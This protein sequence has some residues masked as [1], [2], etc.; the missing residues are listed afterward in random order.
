[1]FNHYSPRDLP[2]LFGDDDFLPVNPGKNSGSRLPTNKRFNKKSKL[3]APSLFDQDSES[4]N[5]TEILQEF[6]KEDRE[7]FIRMSS[8]ARQ[9]NLRLKIAQDEN[10]DEDKVYIE[11]QLLASNKLEAREYSLAIANSLQQD[12]G[13]VIIPTGL[14]KTYIAITMML[15]QLKKNSAQKILFLAPTKPL[16]N[17]HVSTLQTL[18]PGLEINKITG[19]TPKKKRGLLWRASR[20][21]VATPQ[22]ITAE[23]KSFKVKSLVGQSED[24]MML[25]IDELHHQTGH[26]D[27]V[28]LVEFYQK[29]NSDIQFVGFTASPD[30]SL[31]TI[32]GWIKQLRVKNG[33][34]EARSFDSSDIAPYSYCRQVTPHYLDRKL[35]PLQREFKTILAEEL[36]KVIKEISSRVKIS[37]RDMVFFNEKGLVVAIKIRDF[38]GLSLAFKRGTTIPEKKE[39][40]FKL[41]SLYGQAMCYHSA[42]RSLNNGLPEFV[43]FMERQYDNFEKENKKFQ[44]FFC[45]NLQTETI[46]KKLYFYRLWKNKLPAM[47]KQKNW[48][49]S[50]DTLIWMMALNDEKLPV[51]VDIIQKTT[52]QILIFTN[53]RDTLRKVKYYLNMNLPNSRVGILTGTSSNLHD[54]GMSQK[55][56]LTTLDHFRQQKLDILISTSVGEEGLDFPAVDTVI[57]YEPIPDIRRYV[58][59]LGRTARH[60]P[61][62]VHILIYKDTEEEKIFYMVKSREEKVKKIIKYLQIKEV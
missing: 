30:P 56:Q 55:E 17:Q 54:P 15:A 9:L 19:Y 8:A 57:F 10:Q 20:I 59:R 21:I 27:Y 4:I 23:I 58:Q 34:V 51:I 2:N 13:I 14:G 37:I 32:K 38:N 16:V 60:H 45:N 36:T 46:I 26:Y 35:T 24:M 12:N 39:K 28:D 62:T 6:E 42:I 25:V 11:D 22:T 61:G 43:H 44:H 7:R 41:L 3:I 1:M 18:L 48:Q 40:A 52:G 53:Y 29:K 50:E 5:L 49:R 47:F 31:N 33:C